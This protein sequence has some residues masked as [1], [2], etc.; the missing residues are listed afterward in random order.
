MPSPLILPTSVQKSLAPPPRKTR[1]LGRP[2]EFFNMGGSRRMYQSYEGF[3]VETN[4]ALR[5]PQIYRTIRT[6]TDRIPIIATYVQLFNAFVGKAKFSFKAVKEGDEQSV[7]EANR[8]FY[9]EFEGHW[10]R[11]LTKMAA[12]KL[13]G[14]SV[15]EWVPKV[16]EN[17]EGWVLKRFVNL[18]Q[19]T[20]QDILFD[21]VEAEVDYFLQVQLNH[22]SIRQKIPRTR[23]A[24]LVEQ[25]PNVD[26]PFGRGVLTNAAYIGLQILQ[27]MELEQAG[28]IANLRR[29]PNLYAPYALIRQQ[30]STGQLTEE[31]GDELLKRFE[32]ILTDPD[33]GPDIKT[34]L[35]SQSYPINRP[36]GTTMPSN[37]RIWAV[38]YPPPV[39]VIES[40]KEPI[41]R[42]TNA[43]ARMLGIEAL[44]LGQQGVGSF[45]LAE[46]QASLWYQTL[47]ST[48][49]DI[50]R[51]LK[52]VLKHIWVWNGKSEDDVPDVE[53]DRA[54]YLSPGDLIDLVNKLANLGMQVNPE[55]GLVQEI[56]DKAGLSAEHAFLSPEEKLEEEVKR[57]EALGGEMEAGPGGGFPPKKGDKPADKNCLLYTSPSPRD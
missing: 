41:E 30:V 21:P 3:I 26:S 57:N 42:K 54:S 55:G 52:S 19:W 40:G 13:N 14:F 45:A 33:S 25:G 28:N 16:S 44:L 36:D 18:P 8:I 47:D 6:M 20:I 38:E 35:E 49:A 22:G 23:T 43:I 24:Y 27:L 12:F 51:E 10:P 17:G 15:N 4:P 46:V 50:A 5:K 2:F 11:S 29:V 34:V 32:E 1:P 9:S 7:E 31:Q 39:P 56:L 53:Y 48:L 37:E